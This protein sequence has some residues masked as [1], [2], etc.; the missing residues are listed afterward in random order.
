MESFQTIE[1]DNKSISCD[2]GKGNT[3][4]VEIQDGGTL[5][6]HLTAEQ[7]RYFATAVMNVVGIVEQ[8]TTIRNEY[9]RR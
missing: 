9:K 4:L 1:A 2:H 7:A 8:E 6:V 3:V 5:Y